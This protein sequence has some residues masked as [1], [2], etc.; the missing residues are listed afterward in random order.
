MSHTQ[1]ETV[2]GSKEIWYKKRIALKNDFLPLKTAIVHPVDALSLEG[3]FDAAKENLI[4]P[5]LVGPRDKILSAAIEAN[6][7]ISAFELISTRHSN[8]SAEVAVKLAREGKVEALMKGKIHT[9]ELMEAVIDRD[10]GLRTGRRISHVFMINAPHYS[11]PLFLTDAAI[12]IHPNLTEK[13]DIVKNA[14][15][16]FYI[17][18]FGT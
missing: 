4:I 14:I 11:K 7:D 12:N 18:G 3:A 6:I 13:K 17:L 5:V 15:D 1:N 16:L 9:D 2:N 10:N 8:E